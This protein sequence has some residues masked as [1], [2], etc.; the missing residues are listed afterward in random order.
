[1]FRFTI[2]DVLW[3]M[4]V[5]GLAL[6]WWLDRES[7]VSENTDLRSAYMQAVTVRTEASYEALFAKQA[8]K[9]AEAKLKAVSEPPKDS[10]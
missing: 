2:R 4:A 9:K 5:L 8:L 10:N 3:L 6:G 7:L 1:M